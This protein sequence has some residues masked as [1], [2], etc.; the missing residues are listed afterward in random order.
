MKPIPLKS[1]IGFLCAVGLWL[2]AGADRSLAQYS[3]PWYKIGGGG[4]SSSG[5]S[6]SVSGTIGPHDASGPMSG[7]SYSV[8]GGFWVAVAVVTSPAAPTLSIARSG[9]TV[10]ISWPNVSSWTPEQTSDLTVPANW[11][12]STGVTTVNGTNYLTLTSPV[13]NMFFRLK[14][15]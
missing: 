7:G 2:L 3:I 4:G 12:S 5:G 1:Q 11:S 9:G 13:G 10:S 15:Q 6:Y 8:N 14:Q